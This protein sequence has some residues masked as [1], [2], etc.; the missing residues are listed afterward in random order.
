MDLLS[1]CD[2]SQDQIRRIF[3]IADDI[4]RGREEIE[5]K[6]NTTL[7]IYFEKPS[8]RTRV[9]FE[10]AMEQLGGISVF[11]SAEDTHAKRGESVSDIARVL[12]GYSDLIAARMRKHADLLAMAEGST[13]P[14]I[15]AL[16]DLEHP[17]QALAD[18]YTIIQKVGKIKGAR[19]AFVGDIATNTANSLMVTAA[20]LGATISLVGPKECLPNSEYLNK[21]RE[22]GKVEVYSSLEE[23]VEDAD[24]VYTDTFVSM[25]KESEAEERIRMFAPYQ[26]NAAM[27]KFASPRAYVM[28]CMPMYRGTEIT[29]DVV[30]GPQSIIFEQSK[31]KLLINKAVLLFLVEESEGPLDR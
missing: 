1:S 19:I 11:V 7:L 8:T 28:H 24:I 29:T 30:D 3:K 5:V 4:G 13:V 6:E 22:F 14:V 21:A 15:N 25:G 10:V 23:G 18:V 31:N 20:K 27:L 16:T 2:L 9:S 17:T 26:V 12:S